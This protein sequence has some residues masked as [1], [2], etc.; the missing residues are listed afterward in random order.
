MYIYIAIIITC[1]IL[2]FFITRSS[3]STKD[4]AFGESR[5]ATPKEMKNLLS[6]K[7]DGFFIYKPSRY[8]KT[9]CKMSF[10]DSCQHS[11]IIAPTGQGK[12]AGEIIP[13]VLE[14][15]KSA[16]IF[17]P[18]GDIFEAT[19]HIKA[20]RDKF[21]I[22]RVNLEDIRNSKTFN[23]LMYANTDDQLSTLAREL[24]AA[25]TEG[26][27]KT[28]AI[29]T[30]TAI[31]I[32]KCVFKIIK[33]LP[34]PQ[35]HT[36]AN[37]WWFVVNA[38]D[39]FSKMM[40]F[41]HK[42][43]ARIDTNTLTLLKGY[44]D[45]KAD[46]TLGSVMF[47]VRNALDPFSNPDFQI[48][49]SSNTLDFSK[50]RKEKTII[51]ITVP[52]AEMGKWRFF[53]T[54]LINQIMRFLIQPLQKEDLGCY[55]IIDEL[56]NM[57]GRW[58]DFKKYVTTSRSYK[59]AMLCAIQDMESLKAV[60]RE[61]AD[62]IA[63][64]SFVTKIFLPGCT[65]PQTLR[66]L[67]QILGKQ[68]VQYLDAY[69]RE[70]NR[71][72]NLLDASEIRMLDKKKIVINGNKRPMLLPIHFYFKNANYERISKKYENFELQYQTATE[73]LLYPFIEFDKEED[74]QY[75]VSN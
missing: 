35:Y 65:S 31:S 16:V 61:E 30:G 64:G 21:N 44:T 62:S 63:Y 73:V 67:E 15:D 68:A 49:T 33:S 42:Y 24:Y 8:A 46:K 7:N 71:S 23:P 29:W 20:N 58:P 54:I 13:N 69:N 52:F 53:Y 26:S 37:C 34:D 11:L 50:L 48:A 5:W 12:T 17:D 75:D 41:F 9:G 40:P 45:S 4:N 22:Q 32:L 14:L 43:M 72:K 51:Y 18:K 28:E 10:K 57:E 1:L 60:Y 19:A 2:L 70:Q 38:G 3:K 66:L 47:N 27:A 74:K 59:I 25:R 6:Q 39:D 56:T 55:I 36:L